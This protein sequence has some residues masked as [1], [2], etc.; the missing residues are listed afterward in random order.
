V[1]ISNELARCDIK[2]D[3]LPYQAAVPRKGD[4]ITLARRNGLERAI[5]IVRTEKTL[6]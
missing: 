5:G 2:L 4:E 3:E 1:G 6:F